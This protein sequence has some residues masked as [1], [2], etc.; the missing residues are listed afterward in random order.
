ML[1]NSI[2]PLLLIGVIKAFSPSD[3]EYA[4]VLQNAEENIENLMRILRI[5][6]AMI[7]NSTARSVQRL[8]LLLVG[9]AGL[10]GLSNSRASRSNPAPARPAGLLIHSFCVLILL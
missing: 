1:A 10:A 3:A 2:N 4:L 6:C 7:T 9:P 8:H 5:H